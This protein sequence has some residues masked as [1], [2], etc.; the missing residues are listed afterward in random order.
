[1]N[2]SEAVYFNRLQRA[3]SAGWISP[4]EYFEAIRNSFSPDLIGD[5]DD[6]LN[7]EYVDDI[8]Q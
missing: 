6:I 2:L 8:D 3:R 1:M 7:A 5:E 4:D